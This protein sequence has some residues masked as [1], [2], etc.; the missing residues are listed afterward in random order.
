MVFDFIERYDEARRQLTDWIDEG[1]LAPRVTEYDGLDAAP[2]AFVDLLGGATVGT[3][4]V[5]VG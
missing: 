5:R 4:I 1:A 3:T 2:Q